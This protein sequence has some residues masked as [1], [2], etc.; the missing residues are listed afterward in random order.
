MGVGLGGG[1]AIGLKPETVFGTYEDPTVWVPILSESFRYVEGRYF[2]PQ[3]RQQVMVSD[4]K[5]GYYH[6][7]GE[8]RIEVDTHFLPYFLYASRHTV[9]KTGPV[10][11]VYTYKA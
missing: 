2:S 11:G 8:V 3:L 7:E 1:G 6:I 9:T 4:V 5:Q 10:G